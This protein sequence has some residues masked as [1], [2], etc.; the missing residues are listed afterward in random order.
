MKKRT[1][2]ITLKV[3]QL[4]SSTQKR[5]YNI[6]SKIVNVVSVKNTLSSVTKKA[7][8][9]IANAL[10]KIPIIISQ[11]YYKTLSLI[12]NIGNFTNTRWLILSKSLVL[13]SSV[14]R[15]MRIDIFKN[16]TF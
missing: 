4:S 6:V 2:K 11:S 1:E 15:E 16:I 13:T 10:I 3:I 7:Y 14:Y 12:V 5:I 9:N 8:N